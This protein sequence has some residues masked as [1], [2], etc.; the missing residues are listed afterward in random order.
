MS[1]KE[2]YIG[3]KGGQYYIRKNANGTITKVYIK[4]KKAQPK[5]VTPIPQQKKS[6]KKLTNDNLHSILSAI[7]TMRTVSEFGYEGL[8]AF[9]LTRE[10][11]DIL[12]TFD[13][14]EE[15]Y[16]EFMARLATACW[17]GS[18]YFRM[19][20]GDENINLTRHEVSD[21]GDLVDG[22][23]YMNFEGAESHF[24]VWIID[25]PNVW[26]GGTYGGICS[27]TVKKFNREDY[28]SRFVR[29]MRG[30]IE[31]YLYVFQLDN[32]EIDEV[33]FKSLNYMKSNRY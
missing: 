4:S 31:D 24:W 15:T 18:D 6:P 8:R 11:P 32:A 20:L 28:F 21:L 25:G 13:S 12:G 30:S 16:D 7:E 2:I 19:W 22:V 5:K 17:M 3:P 10:R 14:T 33:G 26:Y 29:A 27:I 1:R 23:Y 9:T